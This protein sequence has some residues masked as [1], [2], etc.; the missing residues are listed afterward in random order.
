M[1]PG[2][3]APLVTKEY[4]KNDERMKMKW[5]DTINSIGILNV[6]ATCTT[7][8]ISFY[9]KHIVKRGLCVEYTENRATL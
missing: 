2:F 6:E 4:T 8:D 5:S 7:L 3:H 1:T 9:I